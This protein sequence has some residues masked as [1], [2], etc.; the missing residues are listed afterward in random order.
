M[1]SSSVIEHP[2]LVH[3]LILLITIPAIAISRTFPAQFGSYQSLTEILEKLQ[4]RHQTGGQSIRTPASDFKNSEWQRFK[5][6][7]GK[8]LY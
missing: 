1:C 8:S 3:C 5:T 2:R 6:R 7:A 4:L